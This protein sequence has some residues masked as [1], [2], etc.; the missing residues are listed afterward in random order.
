MPAEGVCAWVCGLLPSGSGLWKGL[1]GWG[2]EV[3]VS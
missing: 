3:I 2:M 1:P